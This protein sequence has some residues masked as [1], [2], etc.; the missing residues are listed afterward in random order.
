VIPSGLY[1]ALESM[2]LQP[3][4]CELWLDKPLHSGFIPKSSLRF[5]LFKIP[6][7]R[8]LTGAHRDNGEYLNQLHQPLNQSIFLRFLRCL[9]FKNPNQRV[10]T[11][12][13][14]D[15][16][17]YLDHLHHRLAL[18]FPPLPPVQKIF[19]HPL[20]EKASDLTETVIGAAIEVHRDKGPGLIE[21]IYEWCLTK[22]FDLRKITYVS[23][24][25]VEISYKGF[26]KEEDL[27]LD[28]L[29]EDSLLIEAKAVTK[30]LPIHKAQLLS[31]MKLLDV[32]VGLL[33][34][35]NEL[36]VIDGIHR[37]IL[38]GANKAPFDNERDV[39][40]IDFR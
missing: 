1:A 3:S 33:I 20:F 18:P 29:I 24:K 30:I 27:R 37:L 7:Q 32:P 16:G 9:L 34:N 35:F 5:L 4:L 40:D 10:L 15:N 21:S 19:M 2:S 31:Y 14:R 13:N 6:N 23:Q 38:P 25:S 36:R 22:E 39:A 8:I 12:G 26:I 28:I 11:E 17:E